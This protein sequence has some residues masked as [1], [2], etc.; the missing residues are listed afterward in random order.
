MTGFDGGIEYDYGAMTMDN[1][2]AGMQTEVSKSKFKAH[3]LEIFRH[4]ETTGEQVIVTD[5]G[6]PAVVVR[7]YVGTAAD[8]RTRLKGSVLRFDAPLDPVADDEWGALA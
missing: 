7:K 8:V 2:Q 1:Q 4:V 3:A 6:A 5:H